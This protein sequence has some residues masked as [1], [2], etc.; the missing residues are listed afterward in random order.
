MSGLFGIS[1]PHRNDN[2]AQDRS[3]VLSFDE[4]ESFV[5]PAPKDRHRAPLR[6]R[7]DNA[8]RSG[9]FTPLL[10]TATKKSRTTA[11]GTPR[12][13]SA[14]SDDTVANNSALTPAAWHQRSAAQEKSSISIT[15]PSTSSPMRFE[16][17]NAGGIREQEKA[18]DKMKKENWE[19]KLKVFLMEKQMHQ[20]S[21][22]HV[23]LAL[24]ENIDYK[25]QVSSLSKDI[26]KY[27]RALADTERK[28]ATLGDQ[29]SASI[30][31]GE[32]QLQHGM[33][34][35][36][37]LAVD[38]LNSSREVLLNEK[39]DLEMKCR[40][41]EEQ[42]DCLRSDHTQV[43]E[44]NHQIV[45][46]Q[47]KSDDLDR[48][49]DELYDSKQ[50]V[51]QAE[52]DLAIL[53][54][55]LDAL[56]REHED[57]LSKTQP[58]DESHDM[59]GLRE[60]LEETDK[61]LE[62]RNATIRSRETDLSAAM[63]QL[64]SVNQRL[65]EVEFR[66]DTLEGDLEAANEQMIVIREANDALEL[67]RGTA[68]LQLTGL[69][70]ECTKLRNSL[71]ERQAQISSLQDELRERQ[72]D[73]EELQGAAQDQSFEYRQLE[74]R[75]EK[76]I[77]ENDVSRKD[78]LE[79]LDEEISRARITLRESERETQHLRSQLTTV[80][81][82]CISTGKSSFCSSWHLLIA[83]EHKVQEQEMTIVKL[84]DELRARMGEIQ[85][86]EREAQ[87]T[88]SR[89]AA[90]SKRSVA[91]EEQIAALES[92]DDV[93]TTQVHDRLR[94]D[95][96]A[97][98]AQVNSL[99]AQL[100]DKDEE[101]I[102]LTE[103]AAVVTTELEELRIS[104]SESLASTSSSKR[105]LE[106]ARHQITEL[107]RQVQ[108]SHDKIIL[109][110]DARQ[111]LQSELATAKQVNHDQAE[112]AAALN[113]SLLN[114]R[115][116][117]AESQTSHKEELT[118]IVNAEAQEKKN[119]S[120]QHDDLLEQK[121]SLEV[122]HDKTLQAAQTANQRL[123]REL[124]EHQGQI[125]S[126]EATIKRLGDSEETITQDQARFQEALQSEAQRYRDKERVLRD[127]VTGLETAKGQLESEL[128]MTQHNLQ[129]TR[130]ELR[131]HESQQ[132]AREQEYEV[133]KKQSNDF[134]QQVTQ[135]TLLVKDAE[136]DHEAAVAQ[137][138]NQERNIGFLQETLSGARR[139]HQEQLL[140]QSDELFAANQ[141]ARDLVDNLS[142]AD[143]KVQQLEQEKK[144]LMLSLSSSDQR[145][146]A[147]NEDVN[148]LRA[149]KLDLEAQL[150][151]CSSSDA[152]ASVVETEKSQL[153]IALSS[154]E[155]ALR[156]AQT[157]LEEIGAERDLLQEQA[158]EAAAISESYQI[159]TLSTINSLKAEI[160]ACQASMMHQTERANQIELRS[161]ENLKAE[162]TQAA[163][164]HKRM[165]LFIADLQES[166]KV[167]KQK[168][169]DLLASIGS[170]GEKVSAQNRI[171]EDLEAEIDLMRCESQATAK[172]SRDKTAK[173]YSSE[174]LES[175]ILE[176]TEEIE[177]T[178]E[179]V[180]A[181]KLELENAE[182]THMKKIHD[183]KDES[184]SLK[185]D[186]EE[187]RIQ[188]GLLEQRLANLQETIKSQNHFIRSLENEVK[189]V[190]NTRADS[191]ADGGRKLS[192]TSRE[193]D[194]L[195]RQLT[196]TK[197]EI[198]QLRSD[199]KIL[200]SAAARDKYS[201]N[202]LS[203]Q[204]EGA[205]R[206][207][208]LFERELQQKEKKINELR[209]YAKEKAESLAIIERKHHNLQSQVTNL[210]LRSSDLSLTREKDRQQKLHAD[211]IAGLAKML[212]YMRSRTSREEAFRADLSY[213][214]L[215][216]DKQIASFQACNQANL[217]IIR[218]IGIYP[219][220]TV[221]L[222]KRTMK[223][224]A[225]VI[226]ATIRMRNLAR[227][228]SAER[229]E[230][231]KLEEAFRSRR[232]IETTR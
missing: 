73:I 77:N 93:D 57:L 75:I 160:R 147:A 102:Y 81:S 12:N 108:S 161:A 157:E 194:D 199:M 2:R 140:K 111:K 29:V 109:L 184:V 22:E 103:E 15:S 116:M 19:L 197:R 193:R 186:L 38:K 138:A 200:E 136:Q 53:Q 166:L 225:H 45:H 18:M 151:R 141:N 203:E 170:S 175:E 118:A 74:Q 218:Q 163:L 91:L 30:S 26:A 96:T 85:A 164:E 4:I 112:R 10:R 223:N 209:S 106:T 208:K 98:R 68:E 129:N 224:V 65:A 13:R 148:A 143:S 82:K 150:E 97:L 89:L 132:Q 169:V 183:L 145:I 64:E 33:S 90:A 176:L 21:P 39:E 60:R 139:E 32:C 58:G 144:R 158:D 62:T 104:S 88:Q 205:S 72:E 228:W 126:M 113:T 207:I 135:L 69:N 7:S 210:P 92:N 172:Q 66:N 154:A 195:K 206:K 17:N 79:T 94:E 124:H 31:H 95:I 23:Q 214:K 131:A 35:E 211:E 156:N 220:E 226:L 67:S 165:T 8:L 159:Q 101:I 16:P 134:H 100:V 120:R 43:E 61:L 36:E 5:A 215:F 37:R 171:I 28:V 119:L 105:A 46:L 6:A 125:A 128:S 76:K 84:Q 127:L 181:Q 47:K 59:E 185:A 25:V 11:F 122:A 1:T 173:E 107:Q 189:T 202:R 110:E 213:I 123:E 55:E 191:V 99:E 114:V 178:K 155:A 212:R 198:E 44:L 3:E 216:Y 177:R 204:V 179:V 14:N 133:L 49:S 115:T 152:I 180:K 70:E 48:T 162:T 153:R 52:E 121:K 168:H 83:I 146:L 54:G 40:E 24:K 80:E 221:G 142:M 149:E 117:L 231:S 229:A 50:R 86:R 41:L 87:V 51:Q 187:S 222:R 196:S 232:L 182:S 188:Y 42:C 230:K 130:F 56:R 167:S 217:A 190:R 9:E 71:A 201:E 227:C 174:R 219:D 78:R 192:Q 137:L 20:S 27:K 63:S 34:E